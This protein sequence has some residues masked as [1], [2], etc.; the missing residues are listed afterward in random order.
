[1]LGHYFFFLRLVAHFLFFFIAAIFS[2]L[3]RICLKNVD[4]KGNM[5][6]SIN[7]TDIIS[8]LYPILKWIG[9]KYQVYFPLELLVT[10]SAN[11]IGT[12]T[13]FYSHVK[14]GKQEH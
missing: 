11:L 12:T 3:N 1:M 5:Y 7:K 10:T 4:N 2:N 8:I 6:S 13:Y 14:P 9:L